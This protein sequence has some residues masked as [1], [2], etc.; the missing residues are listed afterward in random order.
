MNGAD[1]AT[2]VDLPLFCTPYLVGEVKRL[3]HRVSLAFQKAYDGIA[4]LSF[5]ASHA[6]SDGVKSG[7]GGILHALRKRRAV[8]RYSVLQL[9]GA[10][11]MS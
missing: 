6:N 10:L 9:V 4:A 1:A 8:A 11:G 3:P 5:V 7:R 2:R